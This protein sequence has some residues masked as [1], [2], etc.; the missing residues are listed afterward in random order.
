MQIGSTIIQNGLVLNIDVKNTKSYIGSGIRVND[1]TLNRNNGTFINGVIVSSDSMVFNGSNSYVD[2]GINNSVVFSNNFTLMCW[3]KLTGNGG[4]VISKRKGATFVDNYQISIGINGNISF[5]INNNAGSSIGVSSARSIGV[6][7]YGHVTCQLNNGTMLMY[8][9]TIL[10]VNTSSITGIITDI[11][12]PLR[13][14]TNHD[15]NSFFAGNLNNVLFYNR[16]LSN[17]EIIQNYNATKSRYG[18]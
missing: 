16:V 8:I 7:K 9:N 1:L 3:I 2:C 6:N 12:S 17:Q 14:G 18:L 4:G 5:Q 11:T 15:L 13:F 10:D